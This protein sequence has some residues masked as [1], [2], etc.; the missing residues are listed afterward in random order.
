M[1]GWGL[2][3]GTR[4]NLLGGAKAVLI[5]ANHFTS[6]FTFV[7]MISVC[8]VKEKAWAWAFTVFVIDK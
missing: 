8:W 6:L 4:R 5:A 3:A 2:G 7:I 1:E